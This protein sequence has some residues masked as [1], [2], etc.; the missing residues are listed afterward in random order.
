MNHYSP[1]EYIKIDIA[2]QYGLDK[3]TFRQRIAWV[4]SVKDLP[5]KVTQ[6]ESPAQYMAAVLALEDALSG[7]PTGHLVGLDACASGIAILG[8]L[9]G[10]PVT[11]QNTGVIGQKRMDMYAECTKAMNELLE[12]EQLEVHASRK[13][14]K[15]AQMP[16]FYGSKARPREIF[17]EDTYELA[18]FYMAQETVAPG[19]CYM[20]REFLDSWQPYALDHSH[21]L[22]DGFHAVVPVL[23]KFKGKIEIDEL[24]H[25][26]LTYVYE[27][28]VGTEKG[29]A[30]AANMTHAVDAFL[31]RETVRRC[32]YQQEELERVQSLL[33]THYAQPSHPDTKTPSMEQMAINHRFLSLRGAEFITEENVLEYSIEYRTQLYQLICETLSKPS[34]ALLTVHDEFKCHPNYVNHMRETY[35][36]ILAELADSRVGERIIQEVRNDSDYRLEKI[37]HDLGDQIMQGE[38]FLS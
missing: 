25:T 21:T 22:P 12:A 30:V 20:M 2:N 4:D 29:L 31:V 3:K 7:Q 38:Y 27:N 35:M 15:D 23:Q 32:H 10:C 17:G 14:V 8:I 36:E 13:E 11:S 9:A 5:S 16:H 33:C 34:F 6:A 19:A 37:S 18:A 1:L 24:D 28:N 26:T